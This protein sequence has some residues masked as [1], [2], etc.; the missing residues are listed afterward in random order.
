MRK[1]NR[2]YVD[3]GGV[4]GG[5]LN[6]V[7][8]GHDVKQRLNLGGFE[9]LRGHRSRRAV[10]AEGVGQHVTQHIADLYQIRND[11]AYVNQKQIF[12]KK[13]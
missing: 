6:E 3:K 4:A 1:N 11:G 7:V 2:V 13:L 10:A 9:L 5:L 12:L 8:S